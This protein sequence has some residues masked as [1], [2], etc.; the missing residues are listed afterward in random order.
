MAA[1][2]SSGGGTDWISRLNDVSSVE[3]IDG[4]LTRLLFLPI[5]AFFV[6]AANAVEALSRIVI[7]PA[8]A[9]GAGVGDLVNSIFGGSVNILDAGSSATV[10]DISFFGIG[11]FP[12]ALGV[13]FIAAYGLARYTDQEET[14]NLLPFVPFDVPFIGND[15][16]G[17]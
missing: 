14:G 9:F 17:E 5:A 1:S 15:E 6:Q 7:D 8:I 13:V 11:G 2:G 3:D 4:A 12:I 16:E 10:A